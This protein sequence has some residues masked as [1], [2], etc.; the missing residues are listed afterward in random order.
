MMVSLSLSLSFK[1]LKLQSFKPS[2]W[3]ILGIKT[4]E[5]SILQCSL[6]I[7][8]RFVVKEL[9]LQCSLSQHPTIPRSH[10]LN[11]TL[12]WFVLVFQV[13]LWWESL[14]FCMDH[15]PI[16]K[17]FRPWK[18]FP[19]THQHKVVHEA[20]SSIGSNWCLSSSI[21]FRS[22]WPLGHG[23]WPHPKYFLPTYD[24]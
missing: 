22:L 1:L 23:G 17:P 13:H 8:L 4:Q 2:F 5:K 10:G 19:G 3:S 12:I 11:V 14:P 15:H 24:Y 18:I 21:A 7:V 16:S 9:R 6:Q 20:Q